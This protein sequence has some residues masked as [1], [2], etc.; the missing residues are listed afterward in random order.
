MNQIK[1]SEML[2]LKNAY[3]AG[4]NTALAMMLGFEA[5]LVRPKEFINMVN[6]K[7]DLKGKPVVFS[8]WPN[9]E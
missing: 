1:E 4:F 5:N 3:D 6:G 9:K 8:M 2:K 7:E